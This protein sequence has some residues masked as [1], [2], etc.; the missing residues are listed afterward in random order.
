MFSTGK[1]DWGTPP[2]I[3][4]P[5]NAEFSFQ[6]DAA[7]TLF[8][9]KC[10]N[11]FGPDHLIAER[12]DGLA[13]EWSSFAGPVWVNPPYSRGLQA[14]FVWKAEEQRLRGV[15]SVMLLPA[16]TDTRAFHG[17]IWDRFSHRPHPGIE[18]RFLKGRIK[19]VGAPAG[20]PFPSMVV[21]FRG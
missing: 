3:F 18:V 19:F 21:V 6:L 5:L 1:D 16:R 10:S 2:E 11:Y 7:A 9:R 14:E 13:Q 20:A 17:V 12:R 8:N 15:T 4:N